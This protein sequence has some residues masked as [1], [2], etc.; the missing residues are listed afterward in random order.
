MCDELRDHYDFDF[1]QAKPNRFAARIAKEGI[2]TPAQPQPALS[3]QT[4]EVQNGLNV[5]QD[6]IYFVRQ[7]VKTA[8]GVR[9]AKEAIDAIAI[10]DD[11]EGD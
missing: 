10:A 6:V 11:S 8:G 5:H 1:R 2:V 7:L 4:S 3:G 9:Q